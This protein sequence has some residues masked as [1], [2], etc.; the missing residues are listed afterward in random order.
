MVDAFLDAVATGDTSALASDGAASLR[1]RRVVR[2]AER[3]RRTGVV[4]TIGS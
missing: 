1:T 3:A 2:A 4:V